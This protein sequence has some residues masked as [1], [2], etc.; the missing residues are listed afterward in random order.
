MR[1]LPFGPDDCGE[2][3]AILEERVDN[4][5]LPDSHRETDILLSLIYSMTGEIELALESAERGIQ[6]GKAEKS[7][8]HRSGR[9]DSDGPCEN[10]I[11]SRKYCDCERT[12]YTGD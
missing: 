11:R 10:H 9:A 6:L 4:S 12:L 2:A 7:G 3:R 5:T 8:F 1:G